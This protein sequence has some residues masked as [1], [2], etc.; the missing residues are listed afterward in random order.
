MSTTLLTIALLHWLV[1][2]TAGA[3]VLPVS[4]LSAAGQRQSAFF[5]GLGVTTVAAT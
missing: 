3:N 4:Q 1:L 2:V 5:A